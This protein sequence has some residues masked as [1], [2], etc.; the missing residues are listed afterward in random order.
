[1]QLTYLQIKVPQNIPNNV[2][3][4]N[5]TLIKVPL[6]LLDLKNHTER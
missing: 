1:M 3:R 2:F 4:I 5:Q 6:I